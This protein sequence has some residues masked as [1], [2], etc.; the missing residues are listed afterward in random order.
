MNE[1]V[2]KNFKNCFRVKLNAFLL[3]SFSFLFVTHII[4]LLFPGFP[5]IFWK[6]LT[7][8]IF[9]NDI[10]GMQKNLKYFW[11]YI[12]RQ[13]IIKRSPTIKKVDE[14]YCSFDCLATSILIKVIS[15]REIKPDFNGKMLCN[16][17]QLLKGNF[18]IS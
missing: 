8:F 3:L 13:K 5:R 16:N 1:K 11:K 6:F 9:I 17:K 14:S 4:I 10:S 18:N 12:A 2:F 7:I 15:V